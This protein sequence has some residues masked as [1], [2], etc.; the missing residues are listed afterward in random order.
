VTSEEIFS[1]VDGIV[2]GSEEVARTRSWQAH[3]RM[4]DGDGLRSACGRHNVP[5]RGRTRCC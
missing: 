1:E 5:S 3:S 2:G 4:S